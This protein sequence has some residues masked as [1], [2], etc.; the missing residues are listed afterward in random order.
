M[1]TTSGGNDLQALRLSLLIGS[2]LADSEAIA[3]DGFM[4]TSGS[5]HIS[6]PSF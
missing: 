5:L 2:F 1:E 6:M 3:Y 4:G